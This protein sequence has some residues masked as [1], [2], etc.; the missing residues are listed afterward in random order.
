MPL[1]VAVFAEGHTGQSAILRS[2]AVI[3][4]L[5]ITIVYNTLEN[6]LCSR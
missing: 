1:D 6:F 5:C 2:I 4:S 3:V